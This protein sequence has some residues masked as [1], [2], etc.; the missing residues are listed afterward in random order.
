MKSFTVTFTLLFFLTIFIIFI[1]CVNSM[2]GAS[3]WSE[4]VNI[5]IVI[6]CVIC[7][8]FLRTF[9]VIISSIYCFDVIGELFSTIVTEIKEFFQD[10]YDE[11]KSYY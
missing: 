2:Y 11:Y 5:I 1:Q 9:L 6:T 8:K 10:A 3:N 7:I 4:I